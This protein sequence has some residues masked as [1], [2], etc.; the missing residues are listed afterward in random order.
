[1]LSGC[2][3]E[4]LYYQEESFK[5]SINNEENNWKMNIC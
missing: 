2:V 3:A 1:M 4:K 5:I